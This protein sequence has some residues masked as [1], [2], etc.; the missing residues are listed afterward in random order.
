M[1]DVKGAWGNF[2]VVKYD[3]IC[4]NMVEHLVWDVGEDRSWKFQRSRLSSKSGK[5]I[6]PVTPM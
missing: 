4:Y 1:S 2:N 6:T 5:C 3:K